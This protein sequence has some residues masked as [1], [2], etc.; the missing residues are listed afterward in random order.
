LRSQISQRLTHLLNT[1]RK[2]EFC[3][4]V[5]RSRCLPCKRF[6][7][8]CVGLHD[9]LLGLGLGLFYAGA[10]LLSLVTCSK[11]LIP[12]LCKLVCQEGVLV[13]RLRKSLTLLGNQKLI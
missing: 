8:S 13:L 10:S 11:Q 1:L 5:L 12:R 4:C 6:L 3:V 2:P 7:L 9:R